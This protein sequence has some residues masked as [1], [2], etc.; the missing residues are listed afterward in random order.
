MV[1]VGRRAVVEHIAAAKGARAEASGWRG[2]FLKGKYL[3]GH[4]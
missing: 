2:C 4:G 3:A 1:F